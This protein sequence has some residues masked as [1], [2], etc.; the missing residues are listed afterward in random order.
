MFTLK[1]ESIAD[2]HFEPMFAFLL[3]VHNRK[4]PLLKVKQP[5]TVCF[6]CATGLC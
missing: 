3:Y 1:L 6:E 5:E 4:I 2:R